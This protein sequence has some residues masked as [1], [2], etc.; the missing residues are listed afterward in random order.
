MIDL[1]DISFVGGSLARPECVLT[2]ASGDIFAADWRGGVSHLRPEGGQ[3]LY[4][5]K[6]ADLLR[7]L[8]R[9]VS[10]SSRTALSSSLISAQRRAGSG[11]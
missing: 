6:S 2:I 10:H 7:D 8:V 9:M 3:V 1:G 4:L 11:E 5:G